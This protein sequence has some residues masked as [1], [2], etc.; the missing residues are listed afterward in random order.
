[1]GALHE[2]HLSL[3]QRARAESATVVAT[4]FV[5]PAQFSP[6]EDLSRYPRDLDT[7]L[8]L[9]EDNG[10]DVAF[11]PSTE[12]VYPPGFVT[13][14]GVGGPALP[15]EGEARPSH[16]R[17]VTT[18]VAKL[19]LMVAPDVAYFGQKDAQQTAVI[20]RMVVDLN[21]PVQVEVCPT[22]R[23]SDGVAM[24]SRNAYLSP[25]QRVAAPVIYQALSA[26]QKLYQSEER[27]RQVLEKTCREILETEPLIESIDYVAV[28]DSDTFA[29]AADTLGDQP[30][31]QVVAVRI[32]DTHLIDNVVL[33][34]E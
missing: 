14:V 31:T 3:I 13:A 23:E 21:I 9:L 12:E 30:V 7:D 2:G 11:C 20:K 33:K 8:K 28:V 24:S 4:I 34:P 29:Q 17:G 25:K 27:S 26:V 32:G 19:L 1:M 18:V 10:V 16:F 6:I 22:L 15:L 5:N